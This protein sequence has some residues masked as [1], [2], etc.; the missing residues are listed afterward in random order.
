MSV[1]GSPGDP[2]LA[3]GLDLTL[4]S[5]AEG[6]RSGLVASRTGKSQFA[7]VSS[8]PDARGANV[9]TKGALLD[10]GYRPHSG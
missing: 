9:A 5:T 8:I 7:E 3:I 4:V 10:N 2:W 6:G 1:E